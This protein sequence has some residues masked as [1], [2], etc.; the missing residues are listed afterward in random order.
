MLGRAYR[1]HGYGSL[2]YVYSH[3]KHVRGPLMGV[4]YSSGNRHQNFRLAVVVSKKVH[5]SAVIRNRIRRR[6]YEVCHQQVGAIQP[7][8]DI[9]VTIFNDSVATMPATELTKHIMVL[10]ERAKLI[11]LSTDPRGRAMIDQ[12]EN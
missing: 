11:K 2:R 6:V 7:A 10:L 8:H 9:V 12:K 5:K 3:G 4:R 1:F